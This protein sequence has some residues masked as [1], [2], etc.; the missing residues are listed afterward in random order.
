[1]KKKFLLKKKFLSRFGIYNK[2]NIPSNLFISGNFDLDRPRL[3]F[4]E[5]SD[6][7]KLKNADINYI[8][9]EF[10]DLMLEEDYVSLFHFP[11]FKEF[12]QSITGDTN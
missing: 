7:E 5:I 3:S 4:Y 2:K 8:E 11:Q 1:M 6:D 10:N 9:K 12:V